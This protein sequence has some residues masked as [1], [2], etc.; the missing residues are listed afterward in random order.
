MS[1]IL[2]VIGGT[3][4]QGLSVINALLETGEYKIRALTRN[5]SSEKAKDLTA[6]GVEV[7]RADINDE[8]SLVKAFDGSTAIYAMTD[9]FESFSTG[10]PEKA[11]ETE[12]TQGINI[13]KAASKTATLKH[14]VWSTLPNGGKL[15][16]GKY[17][18][19]HFASKNRVDD[20]IKQ[21]KA[22]F[23][24]TTFFWITF[25]GNNFRYPTFTPNFMKSS[26][27]YV[28]L[29]PAKPTTPVKTIGGL[30]N[31]GI[32]ARS[33]L[34]QPAKT[35]PGKCVI[36]HVEDTTSG[37]MLQDWSE[38]TGKKAVYVQTSLEDYNN[39]WPVWGLEMGIML[40]LW[41]EITD[42]SWTDEG[43]VVTKDDLRIDTKNLAGFKG[44]MA[45]MDWTALL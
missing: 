31:I 23:A 34:Q 40:K 30:E 37:K 29:S 15:S 32:F 33:V 39:V 10:G 14:Y 17:E 22:L 35:L 2:T 4:S 6:R 24:K 44:A 27:A 7:V 19:P 25:Y 45:E 11:L 9:F 26:G 5:P 18:V 43:G 20:Y 16:G 42:K 28:Q 21:D 13:A 38:V 41:D 1:P 3:G 8:Q 12:A 36:A